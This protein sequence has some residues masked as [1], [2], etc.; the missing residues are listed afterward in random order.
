MKN[1][2]KYS[3]IPPSYLNFVGNMEHVDYVFS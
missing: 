1:M 2:L 3:V